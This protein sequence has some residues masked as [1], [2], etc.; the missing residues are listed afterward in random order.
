MSIKMSKARWQQIQSVLDE[1]LEQPEH[2]RADYLKT[3]CAHD[4]QLKTDIEALLD[5]EKHRHRFIRSE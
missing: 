1:V 4:S 3:V 2:K 5:A